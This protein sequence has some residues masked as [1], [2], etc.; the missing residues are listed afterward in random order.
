VLTANRKAVT[1]FVSGLF[2]SSLVRQSA[3]RIRAAPTAM[4]RV[5]V[6]ASGWR[7]V[8]SVRADPKEWKRGG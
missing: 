1:V 6:A 4:A 7:P 2:Q 3:G 5:S 8:A